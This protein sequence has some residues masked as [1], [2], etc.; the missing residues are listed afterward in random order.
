MS[1]KVHFCSQ[2][3]QQQD[4]SGYLGQSKLLSLTTARISSRK[5]KVAALRGCFSGASLK[6][7]HNAQIRVLHKTESEWRRRT[8][9]A[10][11]GTDREIE[12]CAM[13]GSIVA[14]LSLSLA[15]TLLA[16]A[17]T[18]AYL[19]L[20]ERQCVCECASTILILSSLK[21]SCQPRKRESSNL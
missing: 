21:A 18:H 16:L 20:C 6:L 15:R 17:P 7:A 10:D 1:L 12:P 11:V 13:D 3:L 19:L 5:R 8:S 2:P 9:S 4:C 14:P